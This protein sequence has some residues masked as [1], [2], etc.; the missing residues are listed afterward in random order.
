MRTVPTVP[1]MR[2]ATAMENVIINNTNTNIIISTITINITTNIVKI[3]TSISSHAFA[4]QNNIAIDYI[5]AM[6][7]TLLSNNQHAP[8]PSISVITNNFTKTVA[9]KA[10]P[11]T[12]RALSPC[13]PL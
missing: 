1:A 11:P 8:R 5:K 7:T 10:P 12:Y 3:I 9:T 6:T 4:V 13:A 2:R